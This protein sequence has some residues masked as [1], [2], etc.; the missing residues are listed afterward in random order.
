[1]LNRGFLLLHSPNFGHR[2]T[3]VKAGCQPVELFGISDGVNLHTAIVFVAHPPT[4]PERRRIFLHKP[5]ET[6][7]L[8][9]AGNEPAAGLDFVPHHC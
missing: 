7:A 8:Y 6:D 5:P 3:A 2:R 1:M 9:A 4:Q